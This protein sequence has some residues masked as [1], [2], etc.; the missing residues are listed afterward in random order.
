MLTEN[1]YFHDKNRV[2]V[3]PVTRQELDE[4]VRNGT[5]NQ[6]SM[7]YHPSFGHVDEMGMG[8]VPYSSLQDFQISFSPSI[9]KFLS[10][11][12]S[13][14]TT[15]LSGPNNQGKSLLLKMSRAQLGERSYL[16][17]CSRFYHVNQLRSREVDEYAR[18]S[19]YDNYMQSLMT[20]QQNSEENSFNLEQVLVELSDT[21][22][23]KLFDV[24]G[25]MLG[26]RFEMRRMVE[27]NR[28]SP[29]YIDMDGEN[30][31]FGSLG[32]R[33]L[34]TVVGICMSQRYDTILIDEPELGLSPKI[35]AQL[36]HFLYNPAARAEYFPNLR[37]LYV[38]THSHIL[39]DRTQ[40]ENNHTVTKEDA[41]IT[42]TQVTSASDMQE[43]QFRMLGN[44]LST[45]FMPSCIVIV[46]GPTDSDY[47]NR[48]LRVFMPDQRIAVITCTGEGGALSQ[49]HLLNQALG[50]LSKSPYGQR[51][52]IL[53][54]KQHERR[55]IP[56]L[57]KLGIANENIIIWDKN[58]IE[59]YYPEDIMCDIFQCGAVQL[60]HL[61]F[62]NQRVTVG[63]IQ[64]DKKDLCKQVI[65][66]LTINSKLNDEVKAK[67]LSH[68][69]KLISG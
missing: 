12:S 49:V 14:A 37:A 66:R 64:Y 68:L 16:V 36:A 58:G 53:L 24:C 13:E 4:A 23:D 40:W 22:R 15:V 8:C 35:Q 47:I 6:R 59:Y 69:A 32:T 45:W 57:V 2:Q 33:V 63:T 61:R 18:Y 1:F 46:E 27:D 20:S 11:R 19:D 55:N 51:T 54:D 43:L 34:L 52:C 29:F 28:L 3:G 31:R 9:E 60:S 41:Q 62:E 17:G 30:L 25:Q 10:S 67:L 48:V 39:L 7:V 5:L 65:D 42:I 44:D 38:S 50:D 26:N 56:R 21:Q